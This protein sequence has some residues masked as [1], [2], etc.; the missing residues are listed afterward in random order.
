MAR[1]RQA[2]SQDGSGPTGQ[3]AAEYAAV[4]KAHA[5]GA[6]R[7]S[8]TLQEVAEA[9][10]G[11]TTIP[12]AAVG[13]IPA[14]SRGPAQATQG[15]R[16]SAQTRTDIPRQTERKRTRLDADTLTRQVKGARGAYGHA[17]STLSR[18]GRHR[19]AARVD[20][21]SIAG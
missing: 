14:A 19:P 9:S 8:G 15:R 4:G 20:D 13:G 7:R 21:L 2:V 11:Q 18:R 5:R 16:Q 10:S 17:R 6:A 1:H 12:A 3:G